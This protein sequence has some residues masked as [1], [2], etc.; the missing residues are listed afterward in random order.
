MTTELVSV[1]YLVGDVEPFVG[2]RTAKLGFTI[3]LN[4]RKAGVE[5]RRDIVT[6]PGGRQPVFEDA[7]GNPVEAFQPAV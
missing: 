6:G 1:R 2:F 7:A 4:V 3:Q 5:F